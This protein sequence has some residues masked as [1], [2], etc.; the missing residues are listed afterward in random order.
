[1]A[2]SVDSNR[3]HAFLPCLLV[4]SGIEDFSKDRGTKDEPVRYQALEVD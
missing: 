4:Y 2:K 1:M 3:I